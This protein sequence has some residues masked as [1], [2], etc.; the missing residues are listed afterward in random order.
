MSEHNATPCSTPRADAFRRGGYTRCGHPL[1]PPS[2]WRARGSMRPRGAAAA[3]NSSSSKQAA[4]AA[5]ARN[6]SSS[7]SSS[8]R[9]GVCWSRLERGR[10]LL[11]LVIFLHYHQEHGHAERQRVERIPTTACKVAMTSCVVTTTV[12]IAPLFIPWHVTNRSII[13]STA[14]P[15]SEYNRFVRSTTEN[16]CRACIPRLLL[17]RLV[18]TT[19]FI[20][21]VIVPPFIL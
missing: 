6:S 9:H 15:L 19:C 2:P 17:L 12:V 20:T 10:V 3:S 16:G 4:A 13:T 8:S 1:V 5:A 14:L 11:V 21:V 7:S 18:A